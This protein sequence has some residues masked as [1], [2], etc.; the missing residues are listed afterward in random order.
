MYYMENLWN[1]PSYMENL[2]NLPSY[3]ENLWN[4]PSYMK[5]K[6]KMGRTPLFVCN[7]NA[8]YI[9]HI[10]ETI[11]VS[12]DT[13]YHTLFTFLY[14]DNTQYKY[15]IIGKWVGYRFIKHILTIHIT[16]FQELEFGLSSAKYYYI[17]KLF[18]LTLGDL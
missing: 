18:S 7:A 13:P 14:L 4:L 11:T 3:M 6:I 5:K 15:F 16:L 1:L 10:M 17:R 12:H 2:W 8:I 9:Y